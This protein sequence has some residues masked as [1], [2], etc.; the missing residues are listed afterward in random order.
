MILAA[1]L[2]GT[3]TVLALFDAEAGIERPLREEMFSSR[4]YDSLEA[5]MGPFLEAAQ[6]KP[7]AACFG[8][9]GASLSELSNGSR[10]HDLRTCDTR[11]GGS[12]ELPRATF[13]TRQFR[14]RVLG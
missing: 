11:A 10:T 3:K 6:A 1:D 5:I 13:W 2:G 8:V 14:A 9:D 12:L 7:T 4:E